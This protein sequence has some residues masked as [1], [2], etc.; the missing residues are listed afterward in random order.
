MSSTNVVST[1]IK[2]G[3][4]S[5]LLPGIIL[6]RQTSDLLL[7]DLNNFLVYLKRICAFILGFTSLN[8]IDI[9]RF[10]ADQSSYDSVERFV[11]D[12]RCQV[13]FV[14]QIN[15]FNEYSS[16]IKRDVS[17]DV[18][19]SIVTS[20]SSSSSLNRYALSNEIHDINPKCLLLV[21][22]K[23]VPT[24]VNDKNYHTQLQIIDF[25]D[26]NHQ[27]ALFGEL[28]D[29]QCINLPEIILKTH[30]VSAQ[31]I[32]NL[33]G[34]VIQESM[35]I[36][37]NVRT[38]IQSRLNTRFT[39]RRIADP[40]YIF[41]PGE[42]FNVVFHTQGSFMRFHAWLSRTYSN[43]GHVLTIIEPADFAMNIIV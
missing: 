40:N 37:N 8:S 3:F 33:I 15:P 14:S 6:K 39:I 4:N 27:K 25:I 10:F 42:E 5:S 43:R 38:A 19:T 18:S 35:N 24:I 17:A 13:L 30:V 28:L 29:G 22:L 34:N 11:A 12:S 7:A 23:R 32:E 36:K 9:D 26:S 21:V 20:S 41:Q 31:N 16:L 2:S 1:I